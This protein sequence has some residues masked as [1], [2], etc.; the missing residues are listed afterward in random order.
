[1][2][3][4]FKFYKF[5]KRIYV[6]YTKNGKNLYCLGKISIVTQEKIFILITLNFSKLRTLQVTK[7]QLPN[8]LELLNFN[9]HKTLIY[10]LNSLKI[11][12]NF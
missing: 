3:Y 12:L 10:K 4:Y 6:F 11:I 2:K 8:I 9:L 1:M 7:F 5:N